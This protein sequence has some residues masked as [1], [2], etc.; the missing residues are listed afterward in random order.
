MAKSF[1]GALLGAILGLVVGGVAT[2]MGGGDQYVYLRN[3]LSV[4]LCIGL[5][6]VAGA[7]A[8]AAGAVVD[9]R[10]PGG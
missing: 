6:A 10:G 3:A 7:V 2:M 8:G 4:V 9:A 5:G 1:A